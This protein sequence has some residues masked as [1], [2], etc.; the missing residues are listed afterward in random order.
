MSRQPGARLPTR[1][2]GTTGLRV[3]V[4][5]LGGF[6]QVEAEQAT[7]DQVVSRYLGAGGNYI[8]TAKGYGGGASETKLGRALRG[9]RDGV[10][11]ASK[12]GARDA[13]GAWR[14]IN[15][16]L[17]RL[18]TDR[19]DVHFYH[20]VGTAA[21]VKTIAA[22]GGA[23]EAFTKAREQGLIRYVGVS[24]H[25]PMTYLDAV[26]HLRIDVALIWGNYLDFCNFPEIPRRV[27]PGLRDAGCGIL[28]MKTLADGFLYRSP[29]MALR[30]VLARDADCLVAGFNSLDML[31]T[32]LD[33]C[34]DLSPVTSEETAATLR[35]APE[36]GAYVC[37]QCKT[38][39]VSDDGEG[40]KRV[41]E[42]EGKV[43]RQMDDRRP[44]DAAQYALRERLKGWF[45][46]AGRAR[47]AYVE[48]GEPGPGLA[49]KGLRPCRYGIDIPRKL[50][51]AHA[52]LGSDGGL[53]LL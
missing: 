3:S 33:V 43:D 4:L 24:S 35:E 38:C 39:A 12:T 25:W 40:L 16:S 5:G 32:D 31:N 51:I 7:I 50:R 1:P 28:L 53:N 48:A 8:E 42:L 46:T 36:F 21:D 10:V 9:R 18:Q 45:G 37:R 2:L 20:G 49:S 34:C 26:E 17:K 29:R 47:A 13:E 41:F 11:L 6:H 14:D 22:R 30:F 27:L 52:K 23:V 15:E 44:V 19:I